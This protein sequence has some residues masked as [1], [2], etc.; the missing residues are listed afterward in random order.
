MEHKPLHIITNLPVNNFLQRCRT[1]QLDVEAIAE[2]QTADEGY[3]I[4]AYIT[5]PIGQ[6]HYG[7]TVLK[8]KKTNWIRGLRRA[9]GCIHCRNR[10][11]GNRCSSCGLYIK[12]KRIASP[13][14]IENCKRYINRKVGAIFR[15]ENGILSRHQ[16]AAWDQAREGNRANT[17]ELSDT[18]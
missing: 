17:S 16:S 5:W 18:E 1:S 7:R 6:D 2:D 3:H 15:D 13:E 12:S 9:Y 4:H 11:G 14:H 10:C 8:P